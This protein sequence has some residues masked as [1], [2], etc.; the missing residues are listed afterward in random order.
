MCVCIYIYIYIYVKLS[1]FRH[2]SA[3]PVFAYPFRGHWHISPAGVSF[4]GVHWF[5]CKRQPLRIRTWPGS[6]PKQWKLWVE[7]LAVP[8]TCASFLTF[9]VCCSVQRV[10]SKTS[11]RLRRHALV[12]C[13]L[14]ILLKQ[15][16]ARV[17]APWSK[18][19]DAKDDTYT[20]IY[21]YIYTHT[22][23][24]IYIYIY[25]HTHICTTYFVS[26]LW[27]LQGEVDSRFA[28]ELSV[29]HLALNSL[30]W[31]LPC[32]YTRC[33]LHRHRRRAHHSDCLLMFRLTRIIFGP[34]GIAMRGALEAGDPWLQSADP[35]RGLES[36]NS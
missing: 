14:A 5:G 11:W 10:F 1:A 35:S 8:R 18:Q 22:S 36:T 33:L 25:T 12:R 7:K 21:I 23:L 31:Y 30:C 19:D 28:C 15:S 34:G 17:R 32:V 20:H 29:V 24:Y 2:L 4:G 27:S 6:E 26:C 13:F 16:W 9:L 3:L